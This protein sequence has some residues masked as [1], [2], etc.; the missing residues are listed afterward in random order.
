MNARRLLVCDDEPAIG[1]LVRHIAEPLGFEVEV[2]TDGATFM[3]RYPRFQP[4][5]VIID[6]VMPGIDGNELIAWLAEQ[7]SLSRLIIVTDY[8]QDYADHAKILA[9]FRGLSPVTSLHKPIDI[10]LLRSVLTA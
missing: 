8:H 10:G 6:M 3:S 4:T 7:Q 9:E 2:T 5:T 1:R